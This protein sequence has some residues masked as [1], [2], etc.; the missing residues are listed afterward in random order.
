LYLY[1]ITM[2]EHLRNTIDLHYLPSVWA[3]KPL[4]EHSTLAWAM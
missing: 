4:A 2:N 3:D 1:R